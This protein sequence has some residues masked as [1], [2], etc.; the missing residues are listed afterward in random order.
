M[1]ELHILRHISVLYRYSQIHIARRLKSF[2]IGPGQYPFLLR[3]C[4]QPG[5]NQDD[6]SEILVID[7]GTTAKAVKALKARGYI[8]KEADPGD[9][10]MRRLFPTDKGENLRAL[11]IGEILVEWREILRQGFSEEEK[12]Q[13]DDLVARMAAN[14]A[15]HTKG[16]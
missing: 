9:R 5:I 14:A 4:R 16:P 10:R 6:L 11:L 8:K 7:K 15:K 1:H 3:I 13:V 12:V 2:D